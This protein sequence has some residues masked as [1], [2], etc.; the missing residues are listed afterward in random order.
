MSLGNRLK[1]TF[2][3]KF[4]TL[5]YTVFGVVKFFFPKPV[6]LLTDFA[7]ALRDVFIFCN[8]KIDKGYMFMRIVNF[9]PI[10]KLVWDVKRILTIFEI[11]SVPH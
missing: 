1:R 2:C 7:I 3:I 10:Q 8:S 6:A 9:M 11:S 4:N 5:S